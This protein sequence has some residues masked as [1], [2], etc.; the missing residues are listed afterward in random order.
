MAV[1]VTLDYIEEE[2]LE[3]E[4]VSK[5]V[6]KS[7]HIRN[8]KMVAAT[9]IHE[10]SRNLDPHIHTHVVIAN[11]VLGMDEKWRTIENNSL[12][13]N[14]KLISAIHNNELAYGLRSLGYG[15]QSKGTNGIFQLTDS[16]GKPLYS[17]EVQDAF[18][19]RP[20]DIKAALEA[21]EV[22]EAIK[23][24]EAIEAKK[25]PNRQDLRNYWEKQALVIGYK[26]KGIKI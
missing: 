12:Y 20:A 21:M 10:A 26:I 8:Q 24:M 7:E 14:I 1:E 18:N 5:G 9:F 6:D 3:S 16:D 11:M 23:T 15:I 22:M 4:Q 2:L 13:S 25:N 19:T 17:Q